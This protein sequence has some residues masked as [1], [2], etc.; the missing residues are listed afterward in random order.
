MEILKLQSQWAFHQ[1][2]S[3]FSNTQFLSWPSRPNQSHGL[4]KHR[5]LSTSTRLWM[6]AWIC[7][8]MGEREKFSRNTEICIFFS[9]LCLTHPHWPLHTPWWPQESKPEKECREHLLPHGAH[10]F[11]DLELLT[12][13]SWTIGTFLSLLTNPPSLEN[14]RQSAFLPLLR[15][16]PAWGNTFWIIKESKRGQLSWFHKS[17]EAD[18]KQG[19]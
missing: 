6:C 17:R 3:P 4:R 19:F 16:C 18:K 7:S 12:E 8:A 15:M 5:H 10:L 13:G 1:P 2:C 11:L 14:Q 9:A